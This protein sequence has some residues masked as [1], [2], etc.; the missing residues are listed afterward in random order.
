MAQIHIINLKDV[1]SRR[2]F[3]IR[4]MKSL[5]LRYEFFEAIKGCSLTDDELSEM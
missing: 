2:V 3:M 5:G 4:Q 1:E